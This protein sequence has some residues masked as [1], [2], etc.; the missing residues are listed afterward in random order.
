MRDARNVK[1]DARLLFVL[2][3]V[4]E[5]NSWIE[6]EDEEED[7]TE[8][9]PGPMPRGLSFMGALLPLEAAGG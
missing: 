5:N 8:P 4:L 1:R 9:A 7:D 6:N 3:L 2:V